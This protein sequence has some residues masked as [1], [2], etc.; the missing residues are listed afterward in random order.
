MKPPLIVVSASDDPS[1][2]K[3]VVQFQSGLTTKVLRTENSKEVKSMI[4]K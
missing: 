1:D 2:F 3:G 4:D